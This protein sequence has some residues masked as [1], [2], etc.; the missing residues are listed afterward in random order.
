LVP[1]PRKP[2]RSYAASRADYRAANTS[3]LIV[4]NRENTMPV[5]PLN[6]VRTPANNRKNTGS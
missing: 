6:L 3:L 4:K 5:A 1:A 2:R